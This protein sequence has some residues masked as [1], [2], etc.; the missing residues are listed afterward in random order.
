ME[1][2]SLQIVS[3]DAAFLAEFTLVSRRAEDVVELK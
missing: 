2:R 3:P 1:L